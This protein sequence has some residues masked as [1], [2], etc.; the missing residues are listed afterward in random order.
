MLGNNPR[1][2]Y[3]S[4]KEMYVFN[5]VYFSNVI[6]MCMNSHDARMI[7]KSCSCND[8]DY[9]CYCHRKPF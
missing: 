1:H 7:M 4:C 3:F 5:V 2:F 6:Q 8:C 9:K